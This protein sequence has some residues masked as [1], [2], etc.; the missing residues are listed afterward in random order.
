[1]MSTDP[2]CNSTN[3]NPVYGCNTATCPICPSGECQ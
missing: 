1:V 2:R 3:T